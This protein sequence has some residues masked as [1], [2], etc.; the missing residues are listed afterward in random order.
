MRTAEQRKNARSGSAAEFPMRWPPEV[1]NRGRTPEER[2]REDGEEKLVLVKKFSK[3]SSS[4]SSSRAGRIREMRIE[5]LV[6][7]SLSRT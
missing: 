1:Q 6:E 3:D 4:S 2:V 7:S 5:K